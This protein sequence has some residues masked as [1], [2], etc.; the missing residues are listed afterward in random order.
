MYKPKMLVEILSRDANNFDLVR[1]IAA[2]A[3]IVG[4]SY[5]LSN[6]AHG[7]DPIQRIVHFD[8]S[9]SLAVDVF[10]FLSGLL[11]CSSFL[12]SGDASKF[13]TARIM[14]IMP[15]LI[16][17]VFMCAFVM[18]PIVSKL[19]VKTYLAIPQVTE[20]FYGNI[21]LMHLQWDL[22]GVFAGHAN[23]AVNGSLWTLPVE[24]LMYLLLLVLGLTG[25][26]FSRRSFLFALA[27]SLVLGYL[28]RGYVH[29]D[30]IN[31]ELVPPMLLFVVG[32]VAALYAEYIPISFMALAPALVLLFLVHGNSLFRPLFYLCLMYAMLIFASNHLIR[33]LKLPGDYS[34]GIYIYGFAVQQCVVEYFPSGTAVFNMSV[35]IPIAIFLG[36]L[37]WT[38]IEKRAL[39]LTSEIVK[40]IRTAVLH[41]DTAILGLL[42]APSI[43][44]CLVVLLLPIGTLALGTARPVL[45]E[46]FQITAWGP[47]NTQA[48]VPFNMQPNG[49]A[50]LWI[51]VNRSLDKGARI[52]FGDRVL[53]DANVADTLITAYVPRDLYAKSGNDAVYVLEM[54]QGRL[55]KTNDVSFSVK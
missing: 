47:D 22:P 29:A 24:V 13:A 43:A 30:R 38:L 52:Y 46:H 36:F 27:G 35:S 17:C 11:V 32:A 39:A 18:G 19:D 44:T 42:K 54:Y 23:T 25:V 49:D 8:Y 45:D 34:Y 1:L 10:F 6:G 9:G 16:V 28:L 55:V 50:A 31:P 20:F 51:R 14:R 4:H 3:V 53:D 37:S 26:L 5:A 33:R 41:R 21:S 12:R 48:G 40:R 15:G 2:T 7:M